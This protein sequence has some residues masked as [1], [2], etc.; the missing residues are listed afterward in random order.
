M[1]IPTPEQIGFWAV[2]LSFTAKTVTTIADGIRTAADDL[3][4]SVDAMNWSSPARTMADAR[5]QN[6][7][8]EMRV[9]A[10]AFDNIATTLNNANAT[11]GP[12]VAS[13]RSAVEVLPAAGYT[14]YD[15]W[16]VSDN[17]NYTA[18]FEQAG[19][20]QATKDAVA[21]IRSDRREEEQ[22]QTVRL[23]RLAAGLGDTD[24][25]IA[26]A[27]STAIDAIG[28]LAPI[29]AGLNPTQAKQ[30]IEAVKDGKATPE[31]L[32]RLKLATVLSNDQIEKLR[33]GEPVDI[34]QEQYDYL[35]AVMR[36]L[37]GMSATD[38]EQL[39]DKLP[40]DDAH[41]VKADLADT[42]QIMSNPQITTASPAVGG[43]PSVSVDRGGMNK[44][45]TKVQSL[46]TENP[47]YFDSKQ[48][49]PEW[50]GR[51]ATI[52]RY[53]EFKSLANLL[54]TGNQRL[55]QGSDI[56]RGLLKQGAAIAG[57]NSRASLV[58]GTDGSANE[59]ANRLLTQAGSDRLAVHDLL[60]GDKRM[61]V[62]VA[63]GQ[64]Y[65]SKASIGALLN[66]DW[67]GHNSG[68]NQILDTVGADAT[69]Q[70]LTLNTQSGE[71]AR[72]IADY[73]S[74]HRAQLLHLDD[75]GASFGDA[76][77]ETTGKLGEL[78]S[79]YLP[80]MAG[81]PESE[82]QTKGFDPVNSPHFDPAALKNI[83]AVVDTDPSAAKAFN[84]TAYGTVAELNSEFGR[85]GATHYELGDWAGKIDQAAQDGAQLELESRIKDANQVVK[86]KTA[87]FDSFRELTA[88]GLKTK[89]PEIGNQV[90]L[91][92]KASSPEVKLETLGSIPDLHANGD[93]TTYGSA[94]T[95]YYNILSGMTQTPEFSDLRSD[96]ELGKYFN[97]KT[98]ELL[99]FKEI[100]DL[101]GQGPGSNLP[102]FDADMSRYIINR[103]GH[104]N[105]TTY[106][107]HWDHSH[108]KKEPGSQP[109]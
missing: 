45:P 31:V 106:D 48:F 84:F 49:G 1:S 35:N 93:T 89:I 17:F 22:N 103:M 91:A 33:N 13:L 23:Q 62:T 28:Q 68:V 94:H 15:D 98:G 75:T 30:D 44:L 39:A 54:D 71:G 32:Q 85:S 83:F 80:S 12:I 16:S 20:D 102:I 74:T 63:A 51:E 70:N 92:W 18:A 64:T 66:H 109:R 46:L 59:I 2:D 52:P 72:A 104:D 69:S 41:A 100:S 90:E 95:R 105:L 108:D 7:V 10:T 82:L 26:T 76:N 87:L 5:I 60:T 42:M 79:K 37:D 61:D 3:N 11:M 38:I 29:T 27:L 25:D 47:A 6:E 40:A 81:V 101:G 9:L 19:D 58:P 99:S 36:D 34:P 97:P 107:N 50:K 43:Q 56:D 73:V 55:G 77:P 67:D 88:Y 57:G 78:M 14:I 53:K 86:E 21:Q 4:K 8:R 65:D 24:H 96:P